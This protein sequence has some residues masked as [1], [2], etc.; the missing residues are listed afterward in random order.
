M[1]VSSSFMRA[2]SAEST[3]DSRIRCRCSATSV[4][5]PKWVRPS[6]CGFQDAIVW[7]ESSH[8][9]TSM[10]GGGVGA[11]TKGYGGMRTPATS[12]T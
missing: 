7:S 4:T 12:P 2:R 6:V 1:K 8:A 10:S 9:S 11:T 3:S 5:W